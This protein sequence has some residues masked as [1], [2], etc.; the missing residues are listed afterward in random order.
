MHDNVDRMADIILIGAAL[1]IIILKIT[2]IITISWFWLFSPIIFLFGF[3]IILAI[4][5]TIACLI[6]MYI[7]NKR[8]NKDERY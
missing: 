6:N 8:R 4:G 7:E 3:G 2:N 5:L 1:T